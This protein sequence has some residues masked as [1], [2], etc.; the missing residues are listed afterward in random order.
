MRLQRMRLQQMRLQQIKLQRMRLQQMRLQQMR[1]QQIKLQNRKHVMIKLLKEIDSRTNNQDSLQIK[2]KPLRP[3]H[4]GEKR[5]SQKS[6][7]QTE[8][9]CYFT[10][11]CYH[12]IYSLMCRLCITNNIASSDLYLNT[13]RKKF[14]DKLC[15]NHRKICE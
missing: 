4:K 14:I 3:L 15:K 13:I 12:E 2:I 7:A 10:Q 11:Q 5:V 6:K 9:N 8:Y 1:L